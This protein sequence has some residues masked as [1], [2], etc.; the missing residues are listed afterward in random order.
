MLGSGFPSVGHVN[1]LATAP[2]TV[3]FSPLPVA[4]TESVKKQ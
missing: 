1:V 3:T 4:S 2:T